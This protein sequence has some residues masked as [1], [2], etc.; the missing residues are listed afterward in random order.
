MK[1]AL[2]TILAAGMLLFLGFHFFAIFNYAAPLRADGRLKAAAVRYC[3]PC[4]HQQ[5]TV[6]VPAPDR[7][8]DLYI[9]NGDG[10]V[11]QPWHN[12]TQG[13]INRHR[14]CSWAGRETELLL[15][16]N[17][18]SYVSYDLGEQNRTFDKAPGFPGFQV[19]ER[20]ASYYFR[21][22]RCWAKGRNYELLLVT[23]GPGK[24]YSYYFKNLSLL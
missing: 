12:V 6:F 22:Y 20:A 8:S 11:W 14:Q 23:Q 5:W 3:Y 18:I 4:F 24:T 9:R 15:L 10:N 21:S 17:A 13:L 19:M 16:T 7:R 1:P 2:K